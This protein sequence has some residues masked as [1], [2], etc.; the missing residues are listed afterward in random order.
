MEGEG[1]RAQGRQAS[2]AWGQQPAVGSRLRHR[3]TKALCAN[4]CLPVQPLEP[5]QAA[6]LKARL[7]TTSQVMALNPS[8]MYQLRPDAA[9]LQVGKGGATGAGEWRG[10]PG[11]R[12]LGGRAHIEHCLHIQHQQRSKRSSPCTSPPVLSLQLPRNHL[13]GPAAAVPGTLPATRLP[14]TQPNPT[15]APG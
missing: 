3:G 9:L 4:C 13:L 12:R 11:A 15:C 10:T 8:N 6:R 7:A 5:R 1:A 14:P 2:A